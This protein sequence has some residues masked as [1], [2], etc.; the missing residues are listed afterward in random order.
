MVL[1]AP[2]KTG[3]FPLGHSIAMMF[4]FSYE[5]P[6]NFNTPDGFALPC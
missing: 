4:S 3:L 6:I 5:T 2:T 1:P